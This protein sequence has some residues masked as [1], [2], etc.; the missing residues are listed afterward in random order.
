[1]HH[2]LIKRGQHQG[3]PAHAVKVTI[4]F[5]HAHENH[6]CFAIK[7]VLAGG[8][9]PFS[10]KD[11]LVECHVHAADQVDV[12]LD[13]GE[14]QHEVMVKAHAKVSLNILRQG[15]NA[16]ALAIENLA[17]GI[18]RIDAP[19]FDAMFLHVHNGNPKIAGDGDHR[20]T[21][22]GKVQ[23]HQPDSVR[24]LVFV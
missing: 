14:V 17:V 13:V 11:W 22:L 2:L 8:K 7:V 19:I 12:L 3:L 9:L 6:R 20:H 10:V 18:S 15:L 16:F 23:A 24:L 1:V 5:A 21:L 4:T